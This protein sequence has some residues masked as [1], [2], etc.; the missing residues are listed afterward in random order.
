[1]LPNPLCTIKSCL[2]IPRGFYPSSQEKVYEQC[3]ASLL[4]HHPLPHTVS[5]NTPRKLGQREPGAKP[6]KAYVNTGHLGKRCQQL[7]PLRMRALQSFMFSRVHEDWGQ[8]LVTPSLI[9]SEALGS[10]SKPIKQ[11]NKE[12][13]HVH[14]C[15]WLHRKHSFMCAH[16]CLQI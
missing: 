7:L 12:H 10:S 3:P 6:R 14:I 13:V 5:S 16:M 9:T 1:M 8:S 2:E 4:K 11:G 15:A